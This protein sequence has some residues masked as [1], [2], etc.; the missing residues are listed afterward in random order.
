M[1]LWKY[2]ALLWLV[3]GI[4]A[5]VLDY[6]FQRFGPEI[7]AA[8]Y[9]DLI[10]DFIVLSFA[11]SGHVVALIL[12]FLYLLRFSLWYTLRYTP[13]YPYLTTLWQPEFKPL[14]S[15]LILCFFFVLFALLAREILSLIRQRS[16]GVRLE[17]GRDSWLVFSLRKSWVLLLPLAYLLEM[18]GWRGLFIKYQLPAYGLW[19]VVLIGFLMLGAFAHVRICKLFS[20]MA[21]LGTAVNLTALLIV[22][23]VLISNWPHLIFRLSVP[24]L[25]AG[26]LFWDWFQRIRSRQSLQCIPKEE[27]VKALS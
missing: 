23:S 26:S 22:D 27:E 24:T 5:F 13:D 6:H 16:W 11:F 21:I 17:R 8:L 9:A 14:L 18:H 7:V 15:A 12:Y 3:L 20:A 19:P 10:R 25:A 2:V 4:H 1:K